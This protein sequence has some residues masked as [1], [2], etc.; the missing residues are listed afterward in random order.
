[1]RKKRIITEETRKKL[2]E[3][4][5]GR[6]FSK[7]T[8][9]KIRQKAL[10]RKHT[11]ES[12]KKISKNNY[13]NG[14][15][16]WNY[17]L[18]RKEYLKHYK[19]GA[20]SFARYQLKGKTYEEIYGNEK[21]QEQKLK[22]SLG[23]KKRHDSGIYN[24]KFGFPKDGTMKIRRAKQIV[25][26]EDTQIEIKIQNYLNQ[27]DIEFFTHHYIS[28]I[29]HAYQCDIFIPVQNKIYQ[30]T[31]IECDGDY[32][33]GNPFK[34]PNPNKLQSEQIEEDRIRTEELISLGFRVIRLWEMDI[35][36]LN[37]IQ[38]NEIIKEVK[39]WE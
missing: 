22:R 34:Y 29:T 9:E 30:K 20:R 39:S 26:K 32:W 4:G 17:K 11:E 10:G 21:A 13:W 37:I 35:K 24:K 36:N 8:K 16:T 31:I 19:N 6:I 7:G 25:P 18:S 27:L 15:H 12:K 2:S 3:S 14:K 23:L 1:M 5:K 33:H 38:F 28:E